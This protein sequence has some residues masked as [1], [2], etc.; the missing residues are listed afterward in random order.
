M[1]GMVMEHDA[2][3]GALDDALDRGAYAV[4]RDPKCYGAALAEA[5]ALLNAAPD[6]GETDRVA[7]LLAIVDRLAAAAL[8]GAIDAGQGHVLAAALEA[9]R[10]DAFLQ[11]ESRSALLA[12]AAA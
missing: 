12:A 2:V 8:A 10:F 1:H 6:L 9:G 7:M 11:P 3:G 4:R 5:T